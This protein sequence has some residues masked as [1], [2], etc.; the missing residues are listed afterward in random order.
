MEKTTLGLLCG[1]GIVA[2]SAVA[3]DKISTATMSNLQ[4][5]F[6]GE[7]NAH[8]RYLAFAERADIEGYAGAASLFRTAARAEEIHAANR[9]KAI[10]KYGGLPDAKLE[11]PVVGSTSENLAAAIKAESHESDE[12]YPAFIRQAESDRTLEAARTF[13]FALAAETEH[14]KLYAETLA[15]LDSMTAS[16]LFYVCPICGFTTA[17]PDFENCPTCAT[18]KERFEEV[19]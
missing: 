19:G 2:L 17:D 18:P 12:M 11:P 13:S 14:A 5:A 6:N 10:K 9:A 1:F 8:A 4:A 3:A 15:N 16:R 7:S